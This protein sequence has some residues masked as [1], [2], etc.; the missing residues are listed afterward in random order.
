MSVHHLTADQIVARP[1]TEV[2]DFFSRPEN[3]GRL[4][5]PNMRFELLSLDREMRDGLRLAYRL[6]PLPG[7][8][9]RWVSR[10]TGLATPG[11]FVDV[12]E[13][14]P[15]ARWE[16]THTFS[17]T[18]IGGVPATT[19]TDRIAY[20]LP[21]GPLG[22][23]AHRL[24]VRS[25]LRAIFAYRRRAIER[26]LPPRQ[27][28]RE[29]ALRV[30]VAGGT[31][32]VGGAIATELRRRGERVVILSHQAAR[33]A[34][35][36]PDDVAVRAADVGDPASLALAL[37]GIDAL[38]ISLAFPNSPM[39]SPRRGRTFEQ[40]DG[41][42]TA[43]LAAAAVSAGVKRIV[44][45]SGAGADAGSPRAWFRA[46]AHA[47]AA[48]AASGIPY[49]IIRPT[50]VYGPADVALNRF[51]GFARWLPF[52]PLTGSGTQ[53]LAPVFVNDLADLAADALRSEAARDQ[54]FEIGGPDTLTMRQIIGVAL[55]V[56][57]L[58]RPLL[59]APAI[60]LKLAAWPLRLLPSPPLTPDAVDFIN[61]PAT[62]DTGPLLMRMPRRLTPLAEGLATYL[63]PLPRPT[64][65]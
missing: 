21:L 42:G 18:S 22:D 64:T 62:V 17:E 30:A 20:E 2:F 33:A 47:E 36:L 25:R 15:Y 53:L 44:Y 41:A 40:V 45:I 13:H 59:P 32:F 6:R 7:F 35:A 14:G 16:H 9:V 24:V 34:A 61:Q 57:R 46:K 8:P 23:L 37:R 55:R 29:D 52:V 60:A 51:L 65:P 49:T 31:G 54:V 10:I 58:R 48:V 56:A 11:A 12:Q 19:I 43:R 27:E 28:P 26:L 5:P 4:T 63:G 38:V 1:R 39:E 3:L 50:W